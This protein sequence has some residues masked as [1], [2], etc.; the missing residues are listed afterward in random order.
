MKPTTYSTN[1]LTT[2]I[3]IA[4][5]LSVTGCQ[6]GKWMTP[7]L[8]KLSVWNKDKMDLSTKE[9]ATPSSRFSPNR[10]QAKEDQALKGQQMANELMAS[11]EEKQQQS[12]DE[13]LPREPYSL[14]KL[15]PNLLNP[16]LTTPIDN[17][18]ETP[19]TATTNTPT[20]N[21]FPRTTN[22]FQNLQNT[23]EQLPQNVSFEGTP[24]PAQPNNSIP[25]WNNTSSIAS[26]TAP[27]LAN[28][29]PNTLNPDIPNLKA[30][31]TNGFEPTTPQPRGLS[32]L[33]SSDQRT[34]NI[35]S[36]TRS[37]GF[38]L[39]NAAVNSATR[40]MTLPTNQP[41]INPPKTNNLIQA[42]PNPT[43]QLPLIPIAEQAKQP[44]S[45][46]D[47]GKTLIGGLPLKT[48]GSSDQQP[49]I[50]PLETDNSF[51]P[52]PFN[53]PSNNSTNNADKLDLKPNM[54]PI[55]PT[56]PTTP[57]AAKIKQPT[58]P[59]SGLPAAMPAQSVE[60][61]TASDIPAVLRTGSGF[62]PGSIKQL[63]PAAPKNPN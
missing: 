3:I 42:T 41:K 46:P 19:Q 22:G 37:N 23:I 28:T 9:L 8:P 36:N 26:R 49:T 16:N 15:N 4:F 62:A 57:E 44:A 2:L 45:V 63:T 18:F 5:L 1:S 25:G 14:D 47:G 52:I 29:T 20:S 34:Q 10:D 11:A 27:P 7:S 33:P 17:G 12:F 51:G 50:T 31:S 13:K 32:P 40:P 35:P 53:P 39:P 38:E 56:V 43:M 48:A 6:S 58:A 21:S 30:K 60:T 55:T 59:T 24:S 54:L 61:N